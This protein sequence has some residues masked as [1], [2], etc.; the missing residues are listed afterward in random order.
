MQELTM[1]DIHHVSGAG[2]ISFIGDSVMMGAC[3]AIGAVTAVKYLSDTVMPFYNVAVTPEMLAVAGFV[4][5]ATAIYG[6]THQT[7]GNAGFNP[8]FF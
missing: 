4:A 2:L 7:N 3:G 5:G 1:N 8:Y 6:L